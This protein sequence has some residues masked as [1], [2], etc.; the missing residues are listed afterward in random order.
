[1]T[2]EPPSEFLLTASGI[3]H[4]VPRRTVSPHTALPLP[5][6]LSLRLTHRLSF[7]CI[8]P[9]FMRTS[10]LIGYLCSGTP[11]RL[12]PFAMWPAFPASDYY[13]GSDAPRFHRPTAGLRFKGELLTFMTMDSAVS[14]RRRL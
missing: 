4:R 8:S 3:Q 1:M 11:D 13:G 14:F 2:Q 6:I 7:L 12:P 5:V 9:M 10:P